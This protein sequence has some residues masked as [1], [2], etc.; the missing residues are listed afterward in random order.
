MTWLTGYLHRKSH[1]INA[2]TGAG[3]NYQVQV[4]VYKTTSPVLTR[5]AKTDM[6]YKRM[7]SEQGVIN[8][9]I[10]VV[11]G[12][13]YAGNR[14]N[15]NE[16]YDVANNTWATKTAY[17]IT[18]DA[19]S[20][21]VLVDADSVT[22][23]H[24]VCGYPDDP[25]V[26]KHYGYDPIA[27]TWTEYAAGPLIMW[28]GGGAVINNKFYIFGGSSNAN[29]KSTIYE[30]DPVTNAWVQKTS[31][32][33][34]RAMF[35]WSVHNGKIYVFTGGWGVATTTV[36]VYDPVAN[37][38]TT[39]TNAPEQLGHASKESINGKIYLHT[40]TDTTRMY[41]YDPTTDSYELMTISSYTPIVYL[42]LECVVIGTKF[43]AIG[44]Q[45]SNDVAKTCYELE[46]TTTSTDGA[47]KVHLG[48]NCRNDFGDIRFTDDDGTTLLDCWMETYTSGTSAVFWVEVK[49]SLESSNQTIYVYYGKA[50]ATYPYLATDTAQG[51]ATFLFFD[52]FPNTSIDTNKWEGDTGAAS[53]SG[54]I[55]THS[56]IA[57]TYSFIRSKTTYGPLV[58]YRTYA[59]RTQV[60]GSQWDIRFGFC[61]D[62]DADRVFVWALTGTK[63]KKF[64]QGTYS[65][66]AQSQDAN[67][68]IIQA[69]FISNALCKYQ[70]D[71][72]TVEQLTTGPTVALKVVNEVC[73]IGITAISDTDWVFV[74]KF[75]ATE[76][77]HSTWGTEE[78]AAIDHYITVT[79]LLG[80]LDSYSR[81]KTIHRTYSE[82]LG[83]LDTKTR[84]KS[85]FRTI[86]EAIGVL[87]TKS[88]TK[89]INRTITELVGLKDIRSRTKTINRVVTELLGLKDI[90]TK[91]AW[92]W[93]LPPIPPIP[94]VITAAVG[95]IKQILL[96][97]FL[98][99]LEQP[100]ED[101]PRVQCDV[102]VSWM[103]TN[104]VASSIKNFFTETTT[105]KAKVA[106]VFTETMPIT[107]AILHE[108]TESVQ[109]RSGIIQKFEE[110]RN[111]TAD[112][113]KAVIEDG[114][115]V[116]GEVTPLL[117]KLRELRR[118][119]EDN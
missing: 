54:S 115:K 29:C 39:L 89:T 28:D 49:D 5:T 76:P 47:E 24:V 32:T 116:F 69:F 61:N 16:E 105:I 80:G 35:A 73:A 23:F 59:K 4:K 107:A 11:G 21:G 75:V 66:M 117:D 113:M 6:T 85:Y 79:E 40:W 94:P 74:S 118:K 96:D 99:W 36:E 100:A 90:I 52:H 88:R 3:A 104:R 72:E 7:F 70:I 108:F 67:Y 87:D 8:G 38:W 64:A 110:T 41:E 103:Q 33:Y 62:N 51:E 93:S 81:S 34:A 14:F 50:D 2:A 27:N 15:Y 42:S 31:M 20:C 68:H 57:N 86:T 53:V 46:I 43:Y 84:I 97:K 78:N 111:I 55:M 10:Y 19:G 56:K 37:S 91:I 1:I 30:Y 58:R 17:P 71:N 77:A 112:L 26:H 82:L 114:L 95:K 92:H 98:G 25:A 63:W 13:D 18:E 60:G 45:T 83:V 12:R 106:H 65:D 119:I 48:G 102:E 101:N 109:I 44:G 9:K 22:R